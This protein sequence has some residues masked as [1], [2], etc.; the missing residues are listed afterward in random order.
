[1]RVFFSLV[2]MRIDRSWKLR[3]G[4]RHGRSRAVT[5]DAGVKKKTCTQS[6]FNLH[7]EALPCV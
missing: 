2:G 5:R 1:M 3:V 4:S 7:A 6:P